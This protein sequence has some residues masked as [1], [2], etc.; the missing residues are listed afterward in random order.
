MPPNALMAR[1]TRDSILLKVRSET[2]KNLMEKDLKMGYPLQARLS[3]IYF[4]RYIE[5]MQKLQ[6]IVMNIPTGSA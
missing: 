1:C 4:T 6:A 3:Q 2:L 5:T